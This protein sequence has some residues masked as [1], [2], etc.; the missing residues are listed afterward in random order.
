MCIQFVRPSSRESPTQ[1]STQTVN[2]SWLLCPREPRVVV[3]AGS[4]LAHLVQ[5][6]GSAGRLVLVAMVRGWLSRLVLLSIVLSL[7]LWRLQYNNICRA[8]S[9]M[10]PRF[11]LPARTVARVNRQ[12]LPRPAV[13]A[14][15]LAPDQTAGQSQPGGSRL[16]TR[17]P[18]RSAFHRPRGTWATARR[19]AGR[20]IGAR[21]RRPIIMTKYARF[22]IQLP[23]ETG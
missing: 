13:L 10:V 17:L 21:R 12:S 20:P 14:G 2:Q 3:S 15:V 1:R 16:P 4:P 11:V 5:T 7:S 8:R 22:R 23:V 9:S 18:V 19:Q 6:G